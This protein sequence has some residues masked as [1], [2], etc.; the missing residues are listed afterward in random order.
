MKTSQLMQIVCPNCDT[1]YDVNAS[2]FG[3]QGRTVRCVRCR[4]TW[5]ARA[6]EPATAD[7]F[8]DTDAAH[9]AEPQDQVFAQP[10][11]ADNPSPEP[12]VTSLPEIDS[13]PIAH[14]PAQD[15]EWT[16][17]KTIA[18]PSFGQKPVKSRKRPSLRMPNLRISLPVAAAAMTGLCIAL[19]MWRQ[20]VVRALPQTSGFFEAIRMP[21]NLRQMAFKDVTITTETVNGAKVFLIEGAI[22]GAAKTPIDIPRLRFVVSDERGR[23]I[24]AW[25]AQPE[26]TVLQPGAKVSFK[27]R[28]ASPPDDARNVTVRFFNRRDLT[29][30][31]A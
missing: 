27:S 5:L 6:E 7:A 19:V 3:P 26:E 30:G 1:S 12:A 15:I 21:V 16:E 29:S 13:P 4:E 28:L 18:A 22:A 23:E 11:T 17:A 20:D 2:A 9:S 8:A 31:R 25:N 24:Y 14:D 10:S